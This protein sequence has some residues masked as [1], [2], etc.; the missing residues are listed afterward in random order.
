[1]NLG[2]YKWPQGRIARYAA[3]GTLLSFVF[4]SAYKFYAWKGSTAV[5]LVGNWFKIGRQEIKLGMLGA[6]LLTILGCLGV[7]AVAFANAK[8]GEYLISVEGELRKVYWPKMKPWFSRTTELWGSAYV[9]VAVVVIL[10]VF[11]YVVDY[12]LLTN[13]VGL[14]FYSRQ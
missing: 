8:V 4:Y 11:I 3:A 7:Y 12:W 1:M 9:V 6:V 14:I 2:L 5:P 13:T 10:S